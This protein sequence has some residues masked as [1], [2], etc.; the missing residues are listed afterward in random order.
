MF[1]TSIEQWQLFAAVIEH[2][3]IASAAEHHHRSQPAV[4]YQL[5][6]LQQRLGVELLQ[7]QGRRLV[8]TEAGSALLAQAQLLLN[9]FHDLELRADAIH[10]GRRAVVNLVVDSMFPQ[11]WLFA[12]L[13]AFHQQYKQTQVHV[14]ESVKDEGILQLQQQA[15][16]LY[17]ISL[18]PTSALEKQFVMDVQFICV[19]HSQHPLLQVTQELRRSQ[20]ASYPMIQVVDKQSQ[21]LSHQYPAAQESWY[22]TSIDAAIG[23]VVNQ[24]GFGWLPQQQVAPLLAD[25]TLASIGMNSR[26]TP[27]YFV[28]DDSSRHDPTVQALSEALQQQIDSHLH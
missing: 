17:L 11:A 24:L 19:A 25:G 14:K 16:D 18:P 12:G 5:N 3:S 4:S 28:R 7:L 13:K 15:G 26:S 1:K 9:G 2:G 23:A 21:Q 22:F 10:A 20:L 6:Q 27:L 8:L